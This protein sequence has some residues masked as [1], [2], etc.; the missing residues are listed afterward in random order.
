METGDREMSDN[1]EYFRSLDSRFTIQ[2]YNILLKD[3]QKSYYTKAPRVFSY[4]VRYL[5][6]FL[7]GRDITLKGIFQVDLNTNTYKTLS[8]DITAVSL[9]EAFN[10]T[11][12]TLFLR[13]YVN[14]LDNM[15]LYINDPD[16]GV[17]LIA[18]WRLE[19]GK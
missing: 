4:T 17:R 3:L 9:S 7:M 19:I 14:P 1:T 11:A 5:E 2:E 6:D 10:R 12:S 8:K 13:M 15:P 18:V 16:D